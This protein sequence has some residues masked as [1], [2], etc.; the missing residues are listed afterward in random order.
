MMP[1]AVR[2]DARRPRILLCDDH[3]LYVEP[4]AA[5]LQIRG[6]DAVVARSPAEVL[7]LAAAEEPDLCLLDLHFPDGDGMQAIAALRQCHPTVPVL[8]LSASSEPREGF[9]AIRAGAAGVLRKDQPI[10]AVFDAVEAVL[11]G[12]RPATP[13]PPRPVDATTER[14]LVRSRLAQLTGRERDVL[15]RLVDGEDTVGIA[16][17]LHIAASTARTHLQNVLL[18]LGVHSRL[19]AVAVV[20]GTDLADEL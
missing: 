15:R 13:P 7:P 5:A 9:A 18:K 20:I 14:D 6:Y 4:V 1:V 17:A 10:T 12:R 3:T 11:T 8:V 19:Q 2:A 16:R